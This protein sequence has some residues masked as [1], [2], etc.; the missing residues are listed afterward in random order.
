MFVPG[1]SVM[2]LS[3]H[4]VSAQKIIFFHFL[5]FTAFWTCYFHIGSRYASLNSII[6]PIAGAC[7][8]CIL[9]S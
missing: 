6:M 1:S 4:K 8:V 7:L 5:N 9:T 2:A 3:A